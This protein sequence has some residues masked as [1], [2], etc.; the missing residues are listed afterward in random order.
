MSR[1]PKNAQAHLNLGIAYAR[2]RRSA[3][4]KAHY[5]QFLKLEP[6]GAQADMVRDTLNQLR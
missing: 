6:T 2:Q 1:E 4:A 5:E 3:K